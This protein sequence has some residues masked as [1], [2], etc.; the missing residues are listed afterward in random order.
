GIVTLGS[1]DLSNLLTQLTLRSTDLKALANGPNDVAAIVNVGSLANLNLTNG[2]SDNYPGY[3]LVLYI[4]LSSVALPDPGFEAVA[5]G[6]TAATT[7][8]ELT[9]GASAQTLTSLDPGA[10]WATLIP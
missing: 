6:G 2:F 5:T 8:P 10:V 3:D 9:T 1:T 7:L 4:N